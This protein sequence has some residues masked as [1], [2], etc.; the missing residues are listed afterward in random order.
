MDS[1]L[2]SI[3][4]FFVCFHAVSAQLCSGDNYAS[5]SSQDQ[6]YWITL[7]TSAQNQSQYFYF[8]STVCE[9]GAANYFSFRTNVTAS[10]SVILTFDHTRGDLDLALIDSFSQQTVFQSNGLGDS[11]SLSSVIL[12]GP[13][14]YYLKVYTFGNVASNGVQYNMT[15]SFRYNPDLGST[16]GDQ[17]SSATSVFANFLPCYLMLA[18]FMI[19]QLLAYAVHNDISA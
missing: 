4:F 1:K 2:F 6:P 18:A 5:F 19:F 12:Y 13:R 11:E 17:H 16:T 3:L 10:V 7:N 9:N 8:N 14:L 15:V